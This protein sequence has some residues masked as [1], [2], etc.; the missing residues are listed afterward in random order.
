MSSLLD[1]RPCE[2]VPAHSRGLHYGDGLFETVRFRAAQAPL[3]SRHMARL[4]AS[5][6]RLALD[7]PDPE[8]LLQECLQVLPGDDGV[9]R[10]TLYRAGDKRGYT[11]ATHTTQ[12]LVQGFEAPAERVAP[13]E[14]VVCQTRLGESPALAGLKH[15][16]RLEQVLAGAEVARAG[17]DEGVVC[18]GRDRVVEGVSA[19][20]FFLDESGWWTPP[21]EQYGVAGVYRSWL[22]ERGVGQRELALDK[23]RHCR[24]LFLAN[25][26]RGVMA[27]ARVREHGEYAPSLVDEFLSQIG[28]P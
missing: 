7:P 16:G 26:V 27:V 21:L 9:V 10:V 13:L 24:A 25:S 19:N 5:C 11:P 4:Q 8:I 1:G 14:L 12:R 2:T 6:E 23:L 3:W 15:L 17:A 28:E 22:L 18:D 20:L